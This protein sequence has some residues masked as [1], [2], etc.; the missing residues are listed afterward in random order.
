MD[1]A[2]YIKILSFILFV[3]VVCFYSYSYGVDSEH[4]KMLAEQAISDRATAIKY[5]TVAQELEEL[6]LKRVDNAKTITKT[7]EKIVTRDVYHNSC[8][9]SDGLLLINKALSGNTAPTFPAS[10]LPII[11]KP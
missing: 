8:I 9:D 3:L 5:N 7:V 11:R 4:N 6:K 2:F 1:K 10:D